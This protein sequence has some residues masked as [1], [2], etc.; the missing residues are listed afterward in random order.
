MPALRY[1]AQ[2]FAAV[3]DWVASNFS[4]LARRPGSRI[5]TI[6]PPQAWVADEP[7]GPVTEAMIRA[8]KADRVMMRKA[9][10][11]GPLENQILR[12]PTLQD[13]VN[14]LVAA[15]RRK[16]QRFR[17]WVPLHGLVIGAPKRRNH[18]KVAAHA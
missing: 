13:M 3:A 11:A 4:K 1:E 5:F 15:S 9:V 10:M 12:A 18:S 8:A 14:E 2:I 7:A 6:A 17:L 16:V